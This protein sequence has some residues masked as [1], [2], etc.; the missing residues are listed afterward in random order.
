MESERFGFHLK[1]SRGK[2]HAGGES[3]WS[4]IRFLMSAVSTGHS[5]LI[6]IADAKCAIGFLALPTRE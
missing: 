4:T 6:R 1:P 2:A 3:F 5:N